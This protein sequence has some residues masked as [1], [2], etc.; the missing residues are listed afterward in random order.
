MICTPHL[1]ASTKEAQEDVAVEIAEAVLDALQV[2]IQNSSLSKQ[3]SLS[4]LSFGCYMLPDAFV[5][6][7]DVAHALIS[8]HCNASKHSSI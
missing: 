2:S 8:R 7:D 5:K 6:T 1:G 4:N 3:A